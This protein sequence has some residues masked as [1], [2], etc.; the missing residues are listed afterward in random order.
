MGSRTWPE[1]TLAPSP[2]HSRAHVAP[3]DRAA[4]PHATGQCIIAGV[5][6]PENGQRPDTCLNGNVIPDGAK[7]ELTCDEGFKLQGQQPSCTLTTFRVGNIMCN[8]DDFPWY[9]E[10]LGGTAALILIF[11]LCK[12]LGILPYASDTWAPPLSKATVRPGPGP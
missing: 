4:T 12:V 1:V 3:P 8:D 7:C 11:W 5:N 10:V 2:P 9:L 6:K